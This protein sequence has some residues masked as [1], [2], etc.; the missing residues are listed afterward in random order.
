MKKYLALMS[1]ARFEG[2]IFLKSGIIEINT[3]KI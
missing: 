2:L 3:G 1:N